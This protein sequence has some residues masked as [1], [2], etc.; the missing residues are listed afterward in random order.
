MY[1]YVDEDR[2]R[3]GRFLPWPTLIKTVQDEIDFINRCDESWENYSG[4]TYGIFRNE[5]SEYLGNIGTF[6]FNWTNEH[7]E[8]GYWILGKFE[9]LGYM[10]EAVIA[11]EETLFK[12]GFNRIV[13]RFDPLNNRSGSIPRRLGYHDEGTLRQTIKVNGSFQDLKVFSKIKSDLV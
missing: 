4:S 6:G 2:E 11:L 10:T 1:E 7:C 13:I 12:V 9:G 5:D 8:I 3:L